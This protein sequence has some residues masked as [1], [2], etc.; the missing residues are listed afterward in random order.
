M[1]WYLVLT[2]GNNFK[3]PLLSCFKSPRSPQFSPS[4]K[5]LTLSHGSVFFKSSLHLGGRPYCFRDFSLD[6]KEKQVSFLAKVTGVSGSCDMVWLSF[7]SHYRDGLSPRAITAEEAATASPLLTAK[8]HSRSR[9][10]RAGPSKP[11]ITYF[12]L[13]MHPISYP[14]PIRPISMFPLLL[15][16]LHN[17]SLPFS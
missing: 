15:V 8:P 2:G 9:A 10:C 17:Y 5:H 16:N 3:G 4:P 12:L 7:S 13:P 1:P 6:L 14:H 11:I